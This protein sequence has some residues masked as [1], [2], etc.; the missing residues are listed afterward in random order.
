MFE[1]FPKISRLSR[2]IVISEKL[3]GTNGQIFLFDCQSEIAESMFPYVLASINGTYIAAGSRKR[4]ITPDDDNFGFARW[5]H[6]NQ[7][8]IVSL[9]HG[10][11][12]GEWWGKGIQRGYDLDEK[13]F[14]LFNTSRWRDFADIWN[15]HDEREQAPECCHVTPVLREH[16]VFDTQ[17]IDDVLTDLLCFG[18][19]AAPEYLFPEGVVVY[20]SHSNTLLKKT[21]VGDEYPKGTSK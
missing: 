9:G 11:H 14:S 18:S 20:H 21:I 17:V 4:W 6:D 13:R 3:D 1:S 8:D 15:G 5:V 10:R 16:P 19:K 2:P 7:E 12:F